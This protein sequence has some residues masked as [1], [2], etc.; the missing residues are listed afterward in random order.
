MNNKIMIFFSILIALSISSVRYASAEMYACMEKERIAMD[1]SENLRMFRVYLDRFSVKMNFDPPSV[2]SEKLFLRPSN[3]T[4]L[5]ST[6]SEEFTCTNGWGRT[7]TY[8]M[9]LSTF[10]WSYNATDGDDPAIAFG[11]CERF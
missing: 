9:K 8:N 2:E 4:C 11:S 6:A 5:R 7:F 3:S 1:A 10:V